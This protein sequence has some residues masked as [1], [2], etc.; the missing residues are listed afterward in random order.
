MHWHH[1]A[2]TRFRGALRFSDI[3]HEI[4]E[5][6]GFRFLVRTAPVPRSTESDR[7]KTVTGTW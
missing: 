7:K 1:D 5:F 4:V 2:R 6:Q 3:V